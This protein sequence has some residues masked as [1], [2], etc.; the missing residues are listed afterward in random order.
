MSDT[1]AQLLNRLANEESSLLETCAQLATLAQGTEANAEDFATRVRTQHAQGRLKAEHARA[2][3]DVLDTAAKTQIKPRGATAAATLKR[4]EPGAAALDPERTRI[5]TRNT[6]EGATLKRTE[7]ASEFEADRT[8]L[9]ASRRV[10]DLE[11]TAPTP[12]TLAP[13]VVVKKRFLL[14]TLIGKGGMGLVFGAIDRR[15]EEARDPN[16]RVA[17]K[18]LNSDFQR[19]PQSFMALQREARKAQTLAHPNVVT[20]FDFDRDGDVV[21]MTM[22]LLAG[23]SLESMVRETRGNG[24]GAQQALPI[25]RGIAEGLAYA[26]RKGIVHSDLKPGNVFVTQDGTP[27]IL[28]FGIARAVPSSLADDVED[29]FDA[30]SLGAY[31]EAYATDEMVEGVDPHP[32]DDM[33]ALGIIA[34]ELLTGRHPYQR[35][36]APNARK[37]GIVPAPIKGVS[38]KEARAITACLS[39]DRRERPQNAG[40]FLKLFRGISTVQKVSVAAAIVLAAVAGYVSYQNYLET[41][42]SIPFN[43][44]A[45]EQQQ[46]FRQKM[47]DGREAWTFYEREHIDDAWNAAVDYFADAYRIHPRNREAVAALNAAAKTLLATAKSDE[48]RRA[49]A[50]H[51]QERSAHYR[52]YGPVVDAAK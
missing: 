2:L 41:S 34:Y 48:Q 26:H 7:L 5:R 27:K 50:R 11:D 38:R 31:T 21:Y 39:F 40:E 44:L 47:D 29:V 20:V 22:E 35:H 25:I 49:L 46:A 3:L 33:Y 12:S 42:P 10:Q 14:E 13:G 19:H 32:A 45:L 6:E 51:L 9:I 15:K 52:S 28:D 17:L 16:P 1:I 30:G 24:I 18:V 4:P 37:L 23:R 8:E 43:E 36:S